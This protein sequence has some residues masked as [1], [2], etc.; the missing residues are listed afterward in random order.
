MIEFSSPD[1]LL[2][3]KILFRLPASSLSSSAWRMT[4]SSYS[5]SYYSPPDPFWYSFLLSA[6]TSK[7]IDHNFLFFLSLS[8]LVFELTFWFLWRFTAHSL[9]IIL[10]TFPNSL[11]SSLGS[12][13]TFLCHLA[14]QIHKHGH[15]CIRKKL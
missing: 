5:C 9:I 10:S 6:L 11:P 8:D 4:L 14:S 15:K 3:P 1:S 12:R 7:G 2:V 13:R